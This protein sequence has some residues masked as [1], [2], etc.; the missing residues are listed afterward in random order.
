MATASRKDNPSFIKATL[1]SGL[2][3]YATWKMWFLYGTPYTWVP[4]VL[5]VIAGANF[6]LVLSGLYSYFY[7]WALLKQA[8]APNINKGSSAWAT[9]AEIRQAG[10]YHPHPG[11][12]FF[13]CDP[14]GHPIFFYGEGHV[15]VLASSGAGK[16]QCFTLP[17]LCGDPTSAAVMDYKAVLAIQTGPP[18]KKKYK[19]RIINL[20]PGHLHTD[21]LGEPARYNILQILIND[22]NKEG[23]NRDLIAHAKGL[24]K[25][26]HPDPKVQGENQFFRNASRRLLVFC[27]LYIVTQEDQSKATVTEVL[28]LLQNENRLKD[29]LYIASASDC[30]K[31]QLAEMA[32]DYLQK[33]EVPDRRQFESIREGSLQAVEDYSPNSWL[34]E[35]TS[36]SDFAFADLKYENVTIYIIVDPSKREEMARW[37]GTIGWCIKTELIQCRSSRKVHIYLDEGTNFV[38]EGLP[39]DLTGLREYGIRVFIVIQEL[40]EW[41]RIYSRESLETLLSQSEAKLC[42]SILSLKGAE[43]ISRMLGEETLKTLNYQLGHDHEDKV[44]RSVSES[45]RRLLTV[46]EVRRFPD[47]ILFIRS[48]KPIRVRMTGVHEIKPWSRWLKVSPLHGKK[49]KG[50]TRVWLSYFWSLFTGCPIVSEYKK[51]NPNFGKK[52]SLVY[53]FQMGLFL[54]KG[55]F[56]M[57][58]LLVLV[59]TFSL[60]KTPHLRTSYTYYGSDSNP[61]YTSCRYWGKDGPVDTRRGHCPLIDFLE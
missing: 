20:N 45:A 9:P 30:L 19:H 1:L 5:V 48:L 16:T 11:G 17:N 3:F 57:L 12:L 49:L 46:D 7:N 24:A 37:Q 29:A 39:D 14:S 22:W 18:R 13:G 58:P 44:Q 54:L 52:R 26:L 47:G 27:L 51:I 61:A 33:M 36:T 38:I 25:Q 15:L 10:L 60:E 28:L 50:K 4:V 56:A 6:A 34:A 31:G 41:A 23:G 2:F 32:T 59:I 55:F 42:F 35:S 53:I 43:W 40:E 21:I 8:F